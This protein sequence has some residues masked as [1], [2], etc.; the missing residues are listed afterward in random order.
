MVVVNL[1]EMGFTGLLMPKK[2]TIIHLIKTRIV[3]LGKI[4]VIYLIIKIDSEKR[5]A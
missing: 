1:W 3:K 2:K 5:K 4:P